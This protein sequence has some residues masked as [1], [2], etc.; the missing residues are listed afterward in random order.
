MLARDRDAAVQWGERAIA[1][2]TVLDN[3]TLLGR[4]LI[5]TGIA[6][7]M[8]GRFE[9]LHRVRRGTE[10]G[11]ERDLPAIVAHGL[12]QIGSGCGEMRRYD[13]AVPALVEGSAFAARH[14]L[15]AQRR[16]QIAWLARCRFDLGEWDEAETLAL[17]AIAG[18]RTVAVAMFVGLNTLGWLRARRGDADALQTLDEALEIARDTA[19]LQRLWPCAIARAEAGWLDGDLDPH[20]P[21][22]EEV[23]QMALRCRHGIAAGEIG[24]WLQRGGALSTP[25]TV[26]AEPFASW[27]AGDFMRATAGFRQMGCPYE[28]ASVL[29]DTSEL[30]SLRE[31]HATFQRLRAAPM[32]RRVSEALKAQGVRA[33][34]TLTTAAPAPRHPSGLS[35]RELEVLKLVAAGFTNPQIATSL[36]ISRKTAEHHVSNILMKFGATSRSEAAAAAVRIGLVG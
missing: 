13:E 35:D 20:V 25:P 31:A 18:T 29:V 14:N 7:V 21:L 9:G 36:Y 23:F 26:A 10:L 5:Q 8:D 32:V 30:R 16:Y 6:D 17:E 28:T 1:L 34:A 33:S 3:P 2:A 19:H 4:S 15:E 12:S 22:L 27:I 11:R 24:V